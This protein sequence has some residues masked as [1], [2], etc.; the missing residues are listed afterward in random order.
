MKKIHLLCN[1]HLDPVWLWRWQEG[2]AAAIS[3]FRCAADFCDEYD[4]FVFNHNESLVYKWVE[5]NEPQ[6]FERIKVHVKSGKWKII[7]G[8]Y[9]QPDANLPSGESFSRQILY[10]KNYFMEKFGVEPETAL[11]FDSFGHTRGLVQILK[12]SGYKNYILA[13]ILDPGDYKW[14]GFDDSEIKLHKSFEGYGSVFGDM[15]RKIGRYIES[16]N[17]EIPENSMI[18]W[19]VGD[20][21]GGASRRDLADIAKVAEKLKERGIEVIHSDP[22]TYFDKIDVDNLPTLDKSVRPFSVGCYTT[23]SRIKKT[24]RSLENIIY[25]TEKMLA[26]ANLVYG[27]HYDKKA[28]EDATED[29]MFCEFHDIL[30][31]SM[32]EAG[33]VD[34]LNRMGHGIYNM[35]SLQAKAFFALA[36]GQPKAEENTIPILVYNPHP[37]PVKTQVSCEFQLALQNWK[38]DEFTGGE[39]FKNGEKVPSQFE[40]EACNMNL[41]WRK[42]LVI[43][44]D[45]EPLTMNRYDC[46]LEIKKV[47]KIWDI[48][49]FEK[50]YCFDNGDMQI[51]FNP[52]TGLIDSY[53]VN[54][55]KMLNKNSGKLI[56]VNDNEDPW[57]MT[58]DSFKDVC[59]E[60]KLLSKEET[61]AF[62]GHPEEDVEPFKIVEDGDVRTVLEGIYGYNK[63]YAT[64]RFFVPKKGTKIRVDVIVHMSE[65]NKMIKLSFNTING[66][67]VGQTAFGTETLETEGKAAVFQKF[68]AVKNDDTA[69]V[70]VNDGTYSGDY[71]DG[72]LNQVLL[73]TAGYAA[74]PLNELMWEEDPE[75]KSPMRM[76]MPRDRY[77]KHID[78]GVREFS[79]EFYGDKDTTLADYNAALFN[80]KPFALSFFPSGDGEKCGSFIEIDNKSVTLSA[81]KKAYD[82]NGYV[83]R[84]YNSAEKA[85]KV[86]LSIPCLGLE[87]DLEFGKFEVK[88][89]RIDP[90]TKTFEETD[91]IERSKC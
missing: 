88:T 34:A 21:G 22:D 90:E 11:N 32:I 67:F 63:S 52:E 44:A 79:F 78:M 9:N 14:T 15:E 58:V 48:D 13:R 40:K 29:L 73:R 50:R 3:T 56:V 76:Y 43:E 31:G 25:M 8:W 69:F 89:F 23:M 83:I 64:V 68:S 27:T 71:E 61:A 6:L 77:L 19:G 30:P 1:A 7:G 62:L 35:E 85:E 12:K 57:G 81:F 46:K 38:L 28:I 20:H 70:V 24:H 18:L 66:E 41:D 37:Y 80:E 82:D 16:K 87:K 42:N 55:K 51:T 47:D 4:G 75:G 84:L 53:Y 17:G 59:G 49:K 36:G 39:V 2:A 74:H 86:K 33:E 45:L 10:G 26:H 60:F 54:G 72:V 5:D 65:A 91:I